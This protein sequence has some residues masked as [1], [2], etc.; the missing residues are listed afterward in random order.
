MKKNNFLFLLI[1]F[2]LIDLSNEIKII[3]DY[4]TLSS[5]YYAF[6]RHPLSFF[7]ILSFPYLRKNLN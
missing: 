6:L 1:I 2:L 5:L 3:F 4:L 7:I